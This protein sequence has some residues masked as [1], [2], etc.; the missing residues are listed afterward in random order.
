[1]NQSN[2]N[3]RQ[4]IPAFPSEPKSTNKK[5]FKGPTLLNRN[6]AL[7]GTPDSSKKTGEGSLA[8]TATFG[9]ESRNIEAMAYGTSEERKSS[10]TPAG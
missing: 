1:M 3:K 7:A 5:F 2:E 6:K 10:D 9:Q 4:L 8:M